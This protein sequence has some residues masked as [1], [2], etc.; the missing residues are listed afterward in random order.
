MKL[1]TTE[2]VSAAASVSAVCA[3]MHVSSLPNVDSLSNAAKYS[4]FDSQS[5]SPQL[6][7]EDLKRIDVDDLEKIDLRWHM[8]MLTMRARRFFRRQDEILE[9]M[10]LHLWVSICLKWSA[11]TATGRDILQGSVGSYDWSYQAEEEPAN[12]AFMAFSSS[13]SSF[14]NEFDVISYQTGLE[15]VEARVLVYKQNEFVFEENIKLLNIEVQLRDN[16]LVT[17]RQK[18]EKAEHERDDLKLKIEKFQTSFKNL[19]KLLP[20]QTNKKTGLGYN[21]QVF[22]CAMFDCDDYLS[23]ESDESC[24]PSSLY[25]RFQPGDGYHAVHPPY[26]GTFMPPK[27][28]LVVNTIPTAVETDHPAFNSTKQVKSPRNSI[29][30]VETSIPAVTP[31]PVSDVVP[32][33][34]VTRPRQ[35]TSNVTKTNSPIRRHITRSLP[36][37]PVIHLLELLLLRLQWLQ[38]GKSPRK[39]AQHVET[40]IPAVTPKSASPKPASS[41]KR[42]N[43]KACFVCKSMD[44]LIKD[45]DYHA[46]KMAQLTTRNDAHMGNHKQYAQMTYHNPQKPM[47]TRPRQATSNITKT[48]SPIRR[49]ITRSLPPKTSNLLP[50]V[51]AV[52]APVELNGGHVAFGSNLKGGKIFG[53][54]KIR[55]GNIYNNQGGLSQMFND[56]LHTCMF[57]CFLSQEE[58]NRVHQAL[59]NPSWMEA[60]QEELLQFKMQK[61]WILVAFSY[62]KRAIGFE[63][64]NHLEKVYKVVKALYGLYQAPRA[65]KFGLQEGKSSSTPID[66]KK[67]L[68]KDP[69]G[70]DVDVHTYRKSTTGGRQF[71]RCRLISW[72]CKKQT[73]VATSSTEAEYVVAANQMVSGKDSSNS[74]MADNLPKIVWY[75]THHITLNEELASPKANGYW[76]MK[77]EMQMRMLKKLMLVM[78]LK[79][80]LVLLMKKFLLLLKNNP[81]H[82]LHHLLHHYNPLKISLQHPRRVENLEFDKVAQA[83]EITKLK[84]RVKKLERRNKVRVLKLR[85]LQKVR[86]SQ[87]VETSDDTVIDDESNQ[88]RMI[89]EMDQDDAVVLEDDKEEDREVADAIKDVEEAKV[90]EI[91][92]DQG[93]QSESQAKIYKIDMDHANKVL[94]M[95]EDE[96]EPAEVQEVVD[97]V[98]TAKLITKVVTA[99]SETVTAASAIITTAEA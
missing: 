23:S 81:F 24:L 17:L 88:G 93:R 14:D 46:K 28:D 52:K 44:H 51:T 96:T 3:K 78:L 56:D 54:G 47:V 57:A 91:A 5:S 26:T 18:L 98:T 64:P 12:Y 97:V 33:I 89:A 43:R 41:G 9:L 7:N 67:P 32:Q 36:L 87:R 58:P 71:L 15:S 95:Q 76:V 1:A 90:D 11:I 99:T 45:C 74:L 4:F 16:T 38:E 2:S 21:S 53:E 34:K 40:T 19:T 86:T 80:M 30:H 48:N 82:L 31:K 85:R 72:Q 62:R 25:D 60:M 35:A 20:S 59:K 55:T 73:V 37:R 75:S 77:K 6:D 50:R 94:S 84:R 39:S 10:D 22:T 69:N 13:S 65:W 27:P 79:E 68:L 83:L 49:H 8:A 70:E 29:Q 66:I 42:R 63:D 61:I 92:Q